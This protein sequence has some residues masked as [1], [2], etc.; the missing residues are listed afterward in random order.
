MSAIVRAMA[1]ESPSKMYSYLAD[2]LRAFVTV[3][4]TQTRPWLSRALVSAGWRD[5]EPLMQVMY[6]QAN[7]PRPTRFKQLCQDLAKI[8]RGELTLDAL[9]SYQMS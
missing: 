8:F 6:E 5:V 2:F 3:Y 7:S 1:K 4:P 9:L